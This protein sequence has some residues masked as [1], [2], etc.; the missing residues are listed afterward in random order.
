MRIEL[1]SASELPAAARR[2]GTALVSR[3][4]NNE[5]GIAGHQLESILDAFQQVPTAAPA[6]SREPGPVD[7]SRDLYLLGGNRSPPTHIPTPPPEPPTVRKLTA[8]TST[9]QP[10]SPRPTSVGSTPSCRPA[11][12][13]ESIAGHARAFATIMTE[14]RSRELER[15]VTGVDADNHPT[16]HSLVRQ[17]SADV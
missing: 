12:N 6:A 1:A 17:G 11:H 5:I 16:Q 7:Q 13:W 9:I 8:W 14:R 2:H 4:I 3:V 15:G 10:T